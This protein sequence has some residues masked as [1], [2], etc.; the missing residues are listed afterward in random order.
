MVLEKKM[1]MLRFL[2]VRLPRGI[3]GIIV[4]GLAFD[5]PPKG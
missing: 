5:N 2:F 3:H 1:E 4:L